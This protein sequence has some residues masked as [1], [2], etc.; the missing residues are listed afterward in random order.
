MDA[1]NS[2]GYA[3]LVAGVSTFLGM[4]PTALEP[5]RYGPRQLQAQETD[6]EEAENPA[7]GEG[8]EP[9]PFGRLVRVPL[10]ITGEVDLR[11][12][13]AV[14]RVLEERPEGSGRPILLLEFWPTDD[15]FGAGSDYFRARSLAE[16]LTSRDLGGVRTIA[17]IPKA[18]QGHAVLVALACEEIAM[19]PEATI[20]DAGIDAGENN[21]GPEILAAYG[22]VAERRKTVP[23]EI[24]IGMVRKDLKVLKVET[25]V[26]TEFVLEEELPELKERRT[27]VGNPQ[28]VIER[29]QLGRFT[30]REARLYGLAS[31]LATGR[32]A[33]ARA[34]GLRRDALEED[35][36]LKDGWRPVQVSVTGAIQPQMSNQIPRLVEEAI[37]ERDVN[38]VC[39]WIDSAGG[40]PEHSLDVANYLSELDPGRVRTVAYVPQEARGDAALIAAACDQILMHP[41]AILGGPGAYA[42]SA[43]EA[44]LISETVRH[45]LAPAKERSW[46]LIAALFDPQWSVHRYTKQGTRQ[47]AYFNDEELEAQADRDEWERQEEIVPPGQLLE[48]TGERALELGLARKT[49]ESF[50]EL[51]QWYGL[52]EDPALVE[53]GWADVLIDA[54]ASPSLAWLLLMAGGAALYAELNTPGMGIG[55]FIAGV[56]FILFFWSRFLQGTAAWLEILLFVA[57][58]A[59]LLLEFFVI[60]G[61]GIFGLGG[62]ALMLLSLV[63]TSQTFVIPQNAYQMDQLTNTLVSIGGAGIGTAVCAYFLSRYLPNTPFL[64]HLLLQP[65]SPEEKVALSH[66]ESFTEF[67]Q[68]VGQRGVTTTQ[69]LPSGKARF[70][71]KTYSVASHDDDALPAG[72]PVEVVQASPHRIVVRPV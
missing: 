11:V 64:G 40:A 32:D 35:P 39:V 38:M 45:Q 54:L 13:Q 27:V 12:K 4:M 19:A 71:S 48:L 50:A 49:V 61:F 46:S 70:G 57:G 63:L 23:K 34:L 31:Y 21:D 44:G 25:D 6:A 65:L 16:F 60:P 28:T 67:D 33:L 52:E 30:G 42:P 26:S 36:S 10:P 3:W 69:L 37:R 66:R 8:I 68:L 53:P 15:R 55:A 18:L 7:G 9:E 29:G 59:C 22:M 14:R 43:E 17:Y 47:T 1:R 2:R 62:A 5:G 51:K 24:A 72:T 41:D 56:C 20:G 58:L